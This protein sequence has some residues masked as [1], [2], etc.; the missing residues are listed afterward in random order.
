MTDLKL[1]TDAP[2]VGWGASLDQHRR[3]GSWTRGQ[4][5]LHI[6]VLEMEAVLYALQAFLS[7]VRHKVI[8]LMCD[9]STVV[10]YIR[11]EGGT[12]SFQ[13]TRLTIRLLR[14]CDR[15][16]IQLLPVHLPGSRNV[17]ADAL[18]RVG[19]T[20]MTEWCLS[21]RLLR[22]VFTAWGTPIVDMFATFANRKL[23]T[24]VSPFPDDRALHVDAM[25]VLWSNMGLLYMFSHTDSFN[26]YWHGS[27]SPS[28][29]Q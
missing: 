28:I 18:S 8:R 27:G 21:D 1:F 19:Q 24:F 2:S 20:L 14:Y 7:H 25:S 13:L 22:P 15:H 23:P 12:R 6:N 5:N 10:A 26:R 17:T 4:C 29:C 9:N 3:F 16:G 11:R